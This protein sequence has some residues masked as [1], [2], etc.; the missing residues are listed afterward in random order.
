[1][2]VPAATAATPANCFDEMRE[3]ENFRILDFICVELRRDVKFI[4]FGS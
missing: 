3:R 2:R 4:D 1:M